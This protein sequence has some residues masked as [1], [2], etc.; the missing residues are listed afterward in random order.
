VLRYIEFWIYKIAVRAR[1]RRLLQKFKNKA[2]S[3]DSQTKQSGERLG[4][5]SQAKASGKLIWFHARDALFA[6][7]L[8]SLIEQLN[9]QD[10]GLNFLV[11]TRKDEKLEELVDLLPKNTVHQFL[12]IDLDKPTENFL[13][14]WKPDVGLISEGEF[15]PVLVKKAKA[16]K[17]PLIAINT[18]MTEN[19]YRK[20]RRLPGLSKPT[21]DAFDLIL[22]QDQ[23]VAQKLK[24]LGARSGKIRV[25]GIMSDTKMLLNYDEGLYSGLSSAIGNRSVW[26]AAITHRDEEDVVVNAHKAAMRRNRGLLLILHTREQNRG[27]HI[28]TRYE[29]Q[30]LNFALQENGD[31]LDDM[32]DVLV[33]DQLENIATYLRLASVTF[34]GGTLSNGETIDPFHPA[35]MG[36]AI[37]HG[38]ACGE[39]EEDYQRYHSAG[40]SQMVSNGGELAQTVNHTIAPSIAATM[41]HAAWEISSEGGEVSSIV[42]SEILEKIAE[43]GTKDAAA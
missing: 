6:L 18:K 4:V 8:F 19:I 31:K 2:I 28:S 22:V 41:A 35:S 15:L 25:T 39:F 12:P 10:P 21:L 38:P 36:S 17:L 23:S 29:H 24:R 1:H 9:E 40:A 3:T 37:I 5:P 33:T 11:T 30:N 14:H 20:W 7:P 34:C 16:L 26:L 42:I 43:K 27:V 13:S 32:T